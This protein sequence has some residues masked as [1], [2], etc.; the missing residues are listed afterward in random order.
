[1]P[2][3]SSGRGAPCHRP[4][5]H[6]RRRCPLIDPLP[7]NGDVHASHA[8][9]MSTKPQIN[10]TSISLIYIFYELMDNPMIDLCDK[11]HLRLKLS[12]QLDIPHVR[13]RQSDHAHDDN[14]DDDEHGHDRP[15][16]PPP[17]P[18]HPHPLPHR[19]HRQVASCGGSGCLPKG[20]TASQSPR[21]PE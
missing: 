14:D 7:W 4:R 3:G 5:R 2:R 9:F 1:M 6:H 8:T 11:S 15:P 17:P 10:D 16:L 18:P 13:N 20:Y 12:T 21:G 19:P